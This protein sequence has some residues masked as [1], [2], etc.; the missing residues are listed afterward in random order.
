VYTKITQKCFPEKIACE[1]VIH[2][3]ESEDYISTIKNRIKADSLLG[4]LSAATLASCNSRRTACRLLSAAWLTAAWLANWL[5][6]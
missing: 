4:Y 5:T 2:V 6:I 1:N 3:S